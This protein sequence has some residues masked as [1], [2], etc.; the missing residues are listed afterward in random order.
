MSARRWRESAEHLPS[1]E[2][3]LV[4]SPLLLL[5]AGIVPLG[6]LLLQAAWCVACAI[7]AARISPT[8]AS[9]AAMFANLVLSLLL[10]GFG[11][12]AFAV[13]VDA[14]DAH[15]NAASWTQ[16]GPPALLLSALAYPVASA[17][18]LRA[19]RSTRTA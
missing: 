13:G 6:I 16:L 2:R 9:S 1:I 11:A 5:V 4:F 18:V 17:I 12:V 10:G 3:F 14:L 15:A 7:W 19:A 8:R